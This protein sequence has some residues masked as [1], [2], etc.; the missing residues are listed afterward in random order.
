MTT[1]TVRSQCSPAVR[2]QAA[3]WVARLH[4]PN[5]TPDVEAGFRRW[6]SEDPERAA[7]VELITDTWEKAAR[8]R[9]GPVEEVRSWHLRGF[10]ISFP[11]AALATAVTVALA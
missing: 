6:M 11:R 10:R 1:N 5:R 8:L 9:R 3:A 7:A 2:A 4:G